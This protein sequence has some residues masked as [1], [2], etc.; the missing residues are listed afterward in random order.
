MKPKHWHK[1]VL[2]QTRTEGRS[3]VF[4]QEEEIMNIA[5]MKFML[6]ILSESQQF[7]AREH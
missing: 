2:Q 4:K 3:E 5:S 6:G 7:R 1:V